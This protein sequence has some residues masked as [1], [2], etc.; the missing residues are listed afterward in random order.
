MPSGL[1]PT[2][3][4]NGKKVYTIKVPIMGEAYVGK[5]SIA[6]RLSGGGYISDYRM[7]IGVDIFMRYIE[8]NH[9]IY[10]IQIWDIAGQRKFSFLRKI[11]YK[12]ANAGIFVFDV[13]R[14]RTFESLNNWIRDFLSFHPSVPIIILG[15][16]KDL[17]SQRMVDKREGL[18]LAKR[19]STIYIETS[20]LTGE[21]VEKAF[22]WI[23]DRILAKKHAVVSV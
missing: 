7:T 4:I 9:G 2:G 10:R 1:I 23:I 21:N 11:F 3:I 20:A 16:K 12:G 13:T 18:E 5:T 6:N 14:R 22:Y 8:N 17:E 19:F 15:N